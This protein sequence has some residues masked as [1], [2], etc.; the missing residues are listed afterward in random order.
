MDYTVYLCFLASDSALLEKHWL[1]D[2]ASQFS[3]KRVGNSQLGPK[4]HCEV[5]LVPK[6][7]PPGP[8][9]RIGDKVFEETGACKH[10]QRKSRF[11][12]PDEAEDELSGIACSIVHGQTVHVQQKKFKRK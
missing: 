10:P 6:H 12:L 5:L 4:I 3:P 8:S 9:L 2:L 11:A 7:A 1:N